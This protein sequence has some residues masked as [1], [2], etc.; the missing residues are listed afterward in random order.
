[1][2][3]ELPACQTEVRRK[4]SR[5]IHFVTGLFALTSERERPREIGSD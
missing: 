3:L 5:G 1:M 4:S 2:A